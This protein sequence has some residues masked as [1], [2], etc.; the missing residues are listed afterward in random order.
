M[1]IICE[2]LDMSKKTWKIYF[3]MRFTRSVNVC[4][5][6]NY[7]PKTSRSACFFQNSCRMRVKHRY[8]A[9]HILIMSHLGWVRV[10]LLGLTL[11]IQFSLIQNN[12]PAAWLLDY[13]DVTQIISA[14]KRYLWGFE[15]NVRRT[16]VNSPSRKTRPRQPKRQSPTL[17]PWVNLWWVLD[18]TLDFLQSIQDL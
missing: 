12:S 8:R 5:D 6:T 13:H 15:S 2:S 3:P 7:K 16:L 14:S 10:D 4:S 11:N 9:G 17:A 1:I 18:P